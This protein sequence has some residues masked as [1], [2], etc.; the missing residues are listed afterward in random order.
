MHSIY[1]QTGDYLSLT[2]EGTTFLFTI[3]CVGALCYSIRC[4]RG[5]PTADPVCT[6]PATQQG[7]FF[8]DAA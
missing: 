1:L 6:Y 7:V 2:E 5:V 3:G 4:G 8:V